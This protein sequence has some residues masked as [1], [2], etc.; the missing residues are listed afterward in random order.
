MEGREE[1]V[2]GTFLVTPAPPLARAAVAGP[3]A[4][5]RV[6]VV[7]L[8]LR[9]P[10]L[11]PPAVRRAPALRVRMDM[12]KNLREVVGKLVQVSEWFSIGSP[13][14]EIATSPLAGVP[15]THSE[16]RE[17]SLLPVSRYGLRIPIRYVV[18]P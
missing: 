12:K 10:L 15:G 11:V 16:L 13:R 3:R 8:A 2:W 5:P 9:A 1:G 17:A 18:G 7:T 14:H 6:R 4:V